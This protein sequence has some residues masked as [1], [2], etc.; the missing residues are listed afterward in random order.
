[1]GMFNDIQRANV[2]NFV[3]VQNLAAASN[4][5]IGNQID[6][7][8]LVGTV[9]ITFDLANVDGTTPTLDLKLQHSDTSGSGFTDVSS[10]AITQVT[11]VAGVQTLFLDCNALKRY[12]KVFMTI[13]G[14]STP[15]YLVSAKGYALPQYG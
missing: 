14:T 12:A 4:G 9:A 13:G 11:T 3:P 6:L 1:M 7:R 15:H 8:D 2:L 10:G 5:L